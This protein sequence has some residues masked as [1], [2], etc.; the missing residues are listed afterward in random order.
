MF[1]MYKEGY[2]SG[3]INLVDNIYIDILQQIYYITTQKYK[4]AQIGYKNSGYLYFT[5]STKFMYL[6]TLPALSY[7]RRIHDFFFNIYWLKFCCN[8]AIRSQNITPPLFLS[9]CFSIFYSQLK[10]KQPHV[11]T[12]TGTLLEN[13]AV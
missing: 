12:P 3:E 4:S 10:K 7:P 6:V 8:S 9:H 2:Y 1:F 13:N 11:K 5:Y